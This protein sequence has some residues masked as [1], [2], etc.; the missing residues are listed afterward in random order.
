MTAEIVH[1]DDVAGLEDRRQDLL[2]IGPEANAVD[3][4]VEDA[5]GGKA[6]AAQGADKGQSSPVAMWRKTTQALALRA[7][8]A[9]R[10]HV[11]LD[12]GLINEDQPLWIDP[13][14]PRS[15]APPSAGDVDAC[16]LQGVNS[17]WNGSPLSLGA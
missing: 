4:S 14:L 1:D 3:R 17:L 13:G 5:R 6:V 7:P 10:R 12:P 8:A 16:L 15:P 11:G 2:D 9:Q